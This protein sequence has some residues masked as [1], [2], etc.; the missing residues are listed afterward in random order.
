M[1]GRPRTS[2]TAHTHDS[3]QGFTL[4]E[5][6]IVI[7]IL[8]ILATVTVFA[9]R[10][11]T[12]K[13]EENSELTDLRTLETA[14]DSYY[15]DNQSNPTEQALVDSGYITELSSLHDITIAGDGSYSITN[16]RTGLVV[17]NGT[18][19]SG[20]GGGSGPVAMS[21]TP[22]TFAG[23][24]AYRFGSTTEILVIAEPGDSTLAAA[25]NAVVATYAAP[26]QYTLIFIETTDV[27]ADMAAIRAAS[28]GSYAIVLAGGDVA[29]D[30]NTALFGNVGAFQAGA[31]SI[32]DAL[33]GFGAPPMTAL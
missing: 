8:G 22:T 15:V 12:D 13:G 23:L 19:G 9:V 17:G 33:G 3:D 24:A 4:V 16:V 6:L 2:A 10:G 26:T 32:E 18:A 11:I 7:V 5:L 27:A 25:F 29:A 20:G 30:P 21:G 31:N 1:H 14:V 28:S